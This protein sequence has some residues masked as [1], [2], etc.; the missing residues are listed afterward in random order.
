MKLGFVW[1]AALFGGAA[2]IYK[3]YFDVEYEKIDRCPE[4][5]FSPTPDWLEE[6]RIRKF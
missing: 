3:R 2:R 5:V 6:T 4:L 1:D